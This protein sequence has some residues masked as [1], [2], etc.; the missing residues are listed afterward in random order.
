MSGIYCCQCGESVDARL[1]TGEE[2]YPHRKDLKALPFWKHDDC[3]NYVG[4]HHK[5][6]TPIKPLG[7]IPTHEIRGWRKTIHTKLDPIW[8]SGRM[9]RKGIYSYLSRHLGFEYHTAKLRTV[10]ECEKVYELV[11]HLDDALDF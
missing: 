1:T 4:C 10:E 6:K 5:T 2:I 8:Q 9:S 7:V 11:L 3:G